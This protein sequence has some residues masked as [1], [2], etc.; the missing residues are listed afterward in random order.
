MP[1][2][3]IPVGS[4]PNFGRERINELFNGTWSPERFGADPTGLLDSSPAFTAAAAAAGD[5]G[6]GIVRAAANGRYLL[7]SNVMITANHVIIDGQGALIVGQSPGRFYISGDTGIDG[8]WSH[9]VENSHIINWRIGDSIDDDSQIARGPRI[10][11]AQDCSMRNII[12][13]TRG[14]TGFAFDATRHCQGSDLI[15]RGARALG[16]SF[17]ILLNICDDTLIERCLVADGPFY[18]AY[19]IKGGE[20]NTIQNSL[21]RNVRAVA[22]ARTVIGFR[23]RG[24][25]PYKS[26]GAASVDLTYPWSDIGWL[27]A[28]VRRAS[29]GSKFIN[30]HVYDSDVVPF[31]TQEAYDTEFLDCGSRDCLAGITLKRTEGSM[32]A[33][34]TIPAA[35][36][37]TQLNIEMEIDDETGGSELPWLAGQSAIVEL[38]FGGVH[39]TT[40]ATDQVGHILTLTAPLP[41]A[42]SINRGVGRA[43]NGTER[44][45]RVRNFRASGSR[46]GRGIYVVGATNSYL[47]G[48]TIEEAELTGNFQDGLMGLYADDLKLTRVRAGNNNQQKL[49][50]R[51]ISLI[52][53]TRPSIFDCIAYDDQPMPTQQQGITIDPNNCTAPSMRNCTGYGNTVRD[54]QA[55]LPGYYNA[56]NPGEGVSVTTDDVANNAVWRCQLSEGQIVEIECLVLARRTNGTDS[57][58][59]QLRGTYTMQGGVVTALAGPVSVQPDYESQAA[60]ACSLQ[61]AGTLVRVNALGMAGHSITWTVQAR[62]SRA[63]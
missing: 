1:I 6:G 27:T 53:C 61:I 54:L 56:N 5:A 8:D 37:A 12:K 13:E 10:S 44:G 42:A 33:R 16:G 24:N 17:G 18:Y 14:G 28:D 22:P 40:A 7:L 9:A 2:D 34:L 52:F 23:D 3:M 29:H 59:Y 41:S 58:R 51:G 20:N 35:T 36:G 43:Q 39:S 46:A 21:V 38:D 50:S 31:V 63:A 25:A 55:W 11:W 49:T 48:V 62:T 19:Q 57:A 15:C 26:A 4:T 47:P 32:D 60:Y 30:C 45:F